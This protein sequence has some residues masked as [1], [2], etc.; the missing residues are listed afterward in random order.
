[1]VNVNALA[2][3]GPRN[4]FV[5]TGTH[6]SAATFTIFP[7]ASG[8][9]A[10]AGRP[11]FAKLGDT[12]YL[13]GSASTGSPLILHWSFLSRPNGS[14]A[15]LSDPTAVNPS[16]V[17]DKD[18][19]YVVELLVTDVVSGEKSAAWV[20]IST[21]NTVPTANAGADQ[22][23]AL[24]SRVQLDGSGSSDADGDALTYSWVL[25]APAGSGATLSDASKPAPTFVADVDG[26]YVLEL[27]VNDGRGNNSTD[28]VIVSTQTTSPI[29]N[30]GANQSVAVGSTVQLDGSA[31]TDPDGGPLSYFWAF[32]YRPAGSTALLSGDNTANPSFVADVPGTYVVELKVTDDDTPVQRSATATVVVNTRN[33]NSAPTANAGV[34]QS[35]HFGGT[36]HLDG[37][38]STDPDGDALS[39][40]WSLINKPSGS[41]A[42]L[43]N[44]TIAN[45]TFV[46]DMTGQYVVQLVVSDGT[47]TSQPSTVLITA[48]TPGFDATPLSLNFGDQL[49]GTTSNSTAIAIANMGDEDLVISQIQITG[50][51][52]GDFAFTTAALPVNV[53][54]GQTTT[55][56]VTFS[57]SGTGNRAA[58]LVVTDNAPGAPHTIALQGNG[59]QPGFSANQ[60]L[61][62]GSQWVDASSTRSLVI[63]NTGTGPLTIS[64]LAI[65]GTNAAEFSLPAD[66]QLPMT[67]SAGGS[68]TIVL[69]FKPA[70]IGSRS[71][72]LTI[73]HNAPASPSTVQLTGG[74]VRFLPQPASVTF[75]NQLIHTTSAPQSL[76]INNNSSVD[77]VVSTLFITGANAS[78]F[79]FG[80]ETLPI[81]VG[82]GGS[83]TLQVTFTPQAAGAR[84]A[85]L[86]IASNAPGSPHPV[87][88]AGTG[89]APVFAAA[90]TDVNFNDQEIGT[91]SNQIP[92]TISNSGDGDLII[93]ALDLS[94]THHADFAVIAPVL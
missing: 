47:H 73:T 2:A 71:A 62:F 56:N 7:A 38:A 72:N 28:S 6:D 42:A 8:P 70:D 93:T 45:P 13:D 83:K 77:L 54:P 12:V 24:G 46:A 4:I 20:T 9:V 86:T 10:N 14:M 60:N 11:Q 41:T 19:N 75:G 84:S 44:S 3:A 31:S 18:G 29:A 34:P 59:T 69:T 35:L 68:T 17:V 25:K 88:L 76:T 57:P 85:T 40:K 64:N 50:A 21:G 94:G 81:T 78:D 65:G 16:F 63:N 52:A 82:A 80:G 91:T 51:S 58:S 30:A 67:I 37:S 92:V 90:P 55:V 61:D 79:A 53:K 36:V 22:V 5:R 66:L 89:T 39:Y 43:S 87:T 49:V 15:T 23:V 33:I 48:T 27:T 26:D 32:A 74:G 1:Q